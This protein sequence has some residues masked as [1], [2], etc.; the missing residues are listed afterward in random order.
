[1]PKAQNAKNAQ[2]TL[3]TLDSANFTNAPSTSNTLSTSKSKNTL[4]TPKSTNTPNINNP[5]NAKT[6]P[7]TRQKGLRGENIARSWLISHGFKILE[8]NFFARFGE[9]DI[10]A[11]KDNVLHFIEVKCYQTSNPIYAITPKKLSKIY[12]SIEVFLSESFACNEWLQGDF[13]A[14]EEGISYCVDALLI[15]GDCVQFM[16][17]LSLDSS[18]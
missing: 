6:T 16:Q 13:N 8:C 4:N 15:W 11:H 5:P 17:N 1:M 3:N 12:Q 10:I 2:N 14:N 7:N 18:L 9:I